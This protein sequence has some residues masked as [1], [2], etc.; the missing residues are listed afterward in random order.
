VFAHKRHSPDGC[1][2]RIVTELARQPY[3]EVIRIRNPFASFDHRKLV[4]VDGK[5]AWTGGRNFSDS[6]FFKH[7]DLSFTLTGPLVCD[8]QQDFNDYWRKQG[9]QGNA[10]AL[11]VETDGLAPIPAANAL[12]RVI[13]TAPGNHELTRTLYGAIDG[14]RH[15][16]YVENVYFS[17]GPLV[18]RLARARRRGLDV[19]AVL[20]CSSSSSAINRTNR[21]VANRLL[22]SGVRVYIYPI[23]THMKA[24]CVDGCWAYIG[25]GNFDPL[26]LR[27]NHEMGL[28][29]GAGPLIGEIE[30]R[31]FHT[32]F[33]PEWEL[34]EP[35]PLNWGD[36]ACELL[37][38]LAL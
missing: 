36:Y 7:H 8:L 38:S 18:Y 16:V 34:T 35:L 20:T 15:H 11:A 14:A 37:A 29:I 22:K 25:T 12:A 24:A 1:V 10:P 19:R 9:G 4:L 30:E 13:M 21:V 17:D 23:M 5:A 6:A 27:H 33:R 3:V 31:L 2:N 32:D 26:S 28:S